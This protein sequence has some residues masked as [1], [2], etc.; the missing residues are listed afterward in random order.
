[1]KILITG[2]TGFIGSE[3][4]KYFNYGEITVLTRCKNQCYNTL[5]NSLEDFLDKE[6]IDK[7][8]DVSIHLAGLAHDKYELSYLRRVNVDATVAFARQ[9]AEKG[10]RRF[11]YISSIGVNGNRTKGIPFSEDSSP[12]PHSDYAIAKFEAELELKKLAS[13][14]NFELVIIR[15]PLVY[16]RNAPGNFNSLHKAIS[17]GLPLP[18]GLVSNSR[19]FISVINLCEFIKL[20]VDH[21]LASN[22]TFTISDGCNFS[23]REFIEHICYAKKIKPLLLPIPIFI[24]RGLLYIFGKKSVAIQLFDDLEVNCNKAKKLIGWIPKNDIYDI[25]NIHK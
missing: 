17:K 23:T 9:L 15:P 24:L 13:E 16:G 11:I 12:N 4:V 20:T 21:P 2:A 5:N 25:F 10:L 14:L 1:M 6:C 8:Y 19:S 18:F 7:K 3:L 22:E